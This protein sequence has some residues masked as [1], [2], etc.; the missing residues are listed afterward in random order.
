MTASCCPGCTLLQADLIVASTSSMDHPCHLCISSTLLIDKFTLFELHA[1]IQARANL[2]LQQVR[3]VP[4]AVR[5]EVR[6]PM[7]RSA[8]SKGPLAGF[9]LLLPHEGCSA[10]T[11]ALLIYL[12][13]RWVRPRTGCTMPAWGSVP[14]QLSWMPSPCRASHCGED[15]PSLYACP[16][17]C[18]KSSLLCTG[19]GKH[20][21]SEPSLGKSA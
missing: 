11:S 14:P 18:L 2:H 5:A 6:P 3:L 19:L 16:V 10:Q 13:G 17:Q 4:V 12:L 7:H 8:R 15:Y 9:V 21:E 20:P 1:Q